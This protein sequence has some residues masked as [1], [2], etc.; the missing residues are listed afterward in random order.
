M[1]IIVAKF[2]GT[3]IGNGE[4]I[5]LAAESV[6]KEYMKGNKMVVVVSAI[7]KTTDD[8]LKVVEDSIGDSV[9]EKQM[10][11]IVSM[12]EITIVRLFTST[13]GS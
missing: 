3:S 12:G 10:A 13:L 1:E 8:I 4:R 7:N 5:K 6:V 11:D 2:G 9:T